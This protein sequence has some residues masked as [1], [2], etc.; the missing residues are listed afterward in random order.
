MKKAHAEKRRQLPT[1]DPYEETLATAEKVVTLYEDR[2]DALMTRNLVLEDENARLKSV[3]K[4][5]KKGRCD[6]I[7]IH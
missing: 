3:L 2:L 7:L 1:E 5:Y 4:R 6:E